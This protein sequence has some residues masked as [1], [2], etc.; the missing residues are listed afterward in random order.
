MMGGVGDSEPPS[1]SMVTPKALAAT[2]RGRS[3]MMTL[4]LPWSSGWKVPA[5]MGALP[6]AGMT[7]SS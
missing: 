4:A 5:E 6:S 2:P 1:G 3:G 7:Q